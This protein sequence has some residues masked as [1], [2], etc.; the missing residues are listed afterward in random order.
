MLYWYLLA[1]NEV[2]TSNAK[3][4]LSADNLINAIRAQEPIVLCDLWH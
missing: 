4:I 3:A 1:S 2:S